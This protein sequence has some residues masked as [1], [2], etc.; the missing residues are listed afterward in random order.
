VRFF[1]AFL[2]VL[3]FAAFRRLRGAAFLAAFLFLFAG[4]IV[5]RN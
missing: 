2:V 5:E 1:A 3:R 4:I